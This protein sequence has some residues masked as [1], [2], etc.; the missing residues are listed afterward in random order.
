VASLGISACG[1]LTGYGDVS[2]GD[3][4][5]YQGCTSLASAGPFALAV[6]FEFPAAAD[7]VQILRDDVVIYQSSNHDLKTF[8]DEGLEANAVHAYKCQILVD[9]TVVEGVLG[10]TATVEDPLS[11]YDGCVEAAAIS[12]TSAE[13][14]F[15]FP[16]GATKAIVAR[17]GSEFF[18]TSD[19]KVTKVVS[20]D[21]ETGKVYEFS[22]KVELGG[23]IHQGKIKVTVT[24]TDPLA[25]GFR[26]CDS[27]TA[28]DASRVSVVY[29][30]PAGVEKVAVTRDGV[31]V[32]QTSEKK[33]GTFVDTGLES[34]RKYTY[35]CI[36]KVGSRG[37]PG[38]NVVVVK[39][40][41][42][43]EL[44]YEGASGT[45]T[46]VNQPMSVF[47][48]VFDGN[49]LATTCKVKDGTPALPDGLTLDEATCE[50]SGAPTEVLEDVAITIVA[51]SVAGTSL[52]AALVLNSNP[53]LPTLS[54]VGSTGRTG[55]VG[56][57]MTVTPTLLS[58]NGAPITDC[59]LS[60]SSPALPATLT[61]DGTS[62]VISG[63]PAA[64]MSQTTFRVVARNSEGESPVANVSLVITN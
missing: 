64:T 16:E 49:G 30:F 18:T 13:I 53:G 39:T 34:G 4:T 58:G 14:K 28:L 36:A 60:I 59:E 26:G 38:S 63:T 31:E 9:G 46:T 7:Q 50:V 19:P 21:L 17:N 11:G 43:P 32:F 44:S 41:V 42:L 22:C 20:E 37:K 10:Q 3:A 33:A 35:A 15:Q 1:P 24:L 2:E 62:C 57:P 47:P 55:T 27:L 56:Q 8:T 61:L 25:A 23:T 6:G 29:E 12:D 54:Y 5:K 48:T 45:T 52:D 51:V 40:L